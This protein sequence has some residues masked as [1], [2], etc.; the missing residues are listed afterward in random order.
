V[1]VM[2]KAL[3]VL[4]AVLSIVLATLTM[5]Y[6]ANADRIVSELSDAR[7]ASRSAESELEAQTSEFGALAD[8]KDDRI[9]SLEQR[10]AQA[11]GQ[12]AEL[13]ADVTR[14]RSQVESAE[15]E[16][17]SFK[18]LFASSNEAKRTLADLLTAVVSENQSLRESESRKRIELAEL[19]DQLN[20]SQSRNQVLDET[21]RTLRVTV[22]QLQDQLAG[23]GT[24]EGT[25][26]G[27]RA[28][29]EFAGEVR[30][31]RE[32]TDDQLL[33][34]LDVGTNDS[35]SEDLN[36]FIT[37]GN[38]WIANVRVVE[39]E[40]NHSIARVTLIAEGQ[41]VQAGDRV[42]SRLQ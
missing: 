6:T 17:D 37:R 23:S 21:V 4:A 25:G 42:E 33:V 12:A 19:S 38:N 11:Q 26:T 3:L 24:G 1:H 27:V 13:R 9:Q 20:N 5:A 10:L 40:L 15:L 35:V 2:T 18:D 32:S 36:L 28:S 16:R 30:A 31:V 14:F 34:E 7:A 41:R 29:L 22:T 8:A 39:A